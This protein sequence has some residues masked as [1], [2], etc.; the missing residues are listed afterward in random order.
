MKLMDYLVDAFNAQI[1]EVVDGPNGA[2]IRYSTTTDFENPET[3]GTVPIGNRS[4]DGNIDDF[5]V[6]M[7]PSKEN[8]SV[9]IA[10]ATVNLYSG[11]GVVTLQ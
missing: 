8:P 1:A 11:R 7:V 3:R 4:K 2:F 10:I 6:L 5:N 9:E